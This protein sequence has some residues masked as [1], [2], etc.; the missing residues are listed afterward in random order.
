M[1]RVRCVF[2]SNAEKD[3]GQV[4]KML[5]KF[6]NLL[7]CTADF[8]H[9]DLLVGLSKSGFARIQNCSNDAVSVS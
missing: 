1:V 4:L 7:S 8:A 9:S 5:K 2:W 3:R 6:R